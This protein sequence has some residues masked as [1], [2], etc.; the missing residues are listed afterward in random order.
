M[1]ET[2]AKTTSVADD[3]SNGNKLCG[4]ILATADDVDTSATVCT[5]SYPFRL[6]V[7]LDDGEVGHVATATAKNNEQDTHPG[8]IVGFKLKWYQG[9]C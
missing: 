5:R 1:T 4:R 3:T 8:G 2:N 6:G 7:H 9:S